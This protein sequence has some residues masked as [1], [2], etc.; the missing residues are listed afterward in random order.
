MK[1][2]YFYAIGFAVLMLFDTLMQVSIKF[3]SANAG[4]FSFT[5]TWW[6]SVLQNP[7][8]YGAI[9]G[10]LGAFITWMTLL[11]RVPVGPAF[12]AS[13]IGLIPVL[14]ISAIYLG[15]QFTLLQVVGVVCILLGIALLS[16]SV[17]KQQKTEV[18]DTIYNSSNNS[19]NLR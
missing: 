8:L 2:T 7:W 6:Q 18:A 12:A 9:A 5:S 1:N 15:E 10:Y 3:A 13:H 11:K 4:A 17:A 16:I 19:N 14:F